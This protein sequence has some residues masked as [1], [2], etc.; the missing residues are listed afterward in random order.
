MKFQET[1]DIA[2]GLEVIQSNDSLPLPHPPPKQRKIK[3]KQNPKPLQAP[4]SLRKSQSSPVAQQALHRLPCLHLPL[5]PCSPG[6]SLNSGMLLLQ[7]LFTGCSFC[8]EGPSL[9]IH[10]DLP[11]PPSTL[12]SRVTF[13]VRHSLTMLLKTAPNTPY[14]LV[15]Y[16]SITLITV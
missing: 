11:L 14:P 8:L 6:C 15:L 5:T 9:S 2:Q 7:G 13:P 1:D 3:T 16:F 10:M 12:C 4:A